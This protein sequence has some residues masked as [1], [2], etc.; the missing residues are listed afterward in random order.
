MTA[1][2]MQG[3]YL[4]GPSRIRRPG[5]QRPFRTPEE[6]IRALLLQGQ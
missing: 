3:I 4:H 2:R 6:A 5:R 1:R